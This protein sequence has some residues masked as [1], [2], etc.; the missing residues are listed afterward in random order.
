MKK[1]EPEL[2]AISEFLSGF[3]KESDRGAAL[4]AAALLDE[5]LCEIL[6]VFFADVSASDNLL[7]GFNAPLG[8]F[9]ARITAAYVLSLIQENEYQELN[10]IRKIRNEFG[11]SWKDVSFEAQKI[12]DLCNELPWLGPEEF[13]EGAT[14]RSRFSFAVVVLLTD[15]LWRSRLVSN[16]KRSIKKWP[17]KAREDRGRAYR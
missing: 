9:S 6:K 4:T 16:E 1:I 13:E 8:T 2:K 14:A 3:N 7:A 5:R 11:H 12:R 10:L 15:L 17:N